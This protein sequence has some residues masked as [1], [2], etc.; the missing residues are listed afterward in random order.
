[1]KLMVTVFTILTFL[2]AGMKGP[3]EAHA[4]VGPSDAVDAVIILAFIGGAAY[5]G[6]YFSEHYEVKKK[7]ALEM[8]N[9][10]MPLQKP[11]MSVPAFDEGFPMDAQDRYS[12]NL[13][14]IKF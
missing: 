13:I 10:N 1:M 11:G 9:G 12:L 5:L 2:V 14:N 3:A 6:Y 8:K 7:A 4:D